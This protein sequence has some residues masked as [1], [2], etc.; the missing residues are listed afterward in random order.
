MIRNKKTAFTLA[1]LIIVVVIIAVISAIAVPRLNY[2]AIWK[3]KAEVTAGKIVADLRLARSHAISQAATN[4]V[5]FSLNMVGAEP[6]TSYQIK[7][8]DTLEVIDTLTIDSDTSCNGGSLFEFGPLGNLLQGSDTQ[9]TVSASGKVF[10]ITVTP[11]T[12]S[13]EFIEN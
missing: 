5:G 10:T 11:A 4:T 2:G 12:G 3:K 7:D 9:I 6:Y 1:E 8:L 13:V